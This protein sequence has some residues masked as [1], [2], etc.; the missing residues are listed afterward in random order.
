MPILPGR[1]AR[2]CEVW[3]RPS[4]S[5]ATSDHTSGKLGRVGT[6]GQAPT[7]PSSSPL[8]A[9]AIKIA[10][11][12][13][14]TWALVDTGADFTMMQRGFYEG[15]HVLKNTALKP[16]VRTA[17][18]A[19]GGSLQ[20]AG[21]LEDIPLSINGVVFRCPQMTV[22]DEL[23]YDV[24]LGRDF[25][26][27]HRT[28]VDDITGTIRIGGMSIPL[29][30]RDQV[31]PRRARVRLLSTVTIPA[32]SECVVSGK[33]ERVDGTRP[34]ETG[35]HGIFEPAVTAEREGLL[36]PRVLVAAD[37]DGSVPIILSNFGADEVR[38]LRG[39]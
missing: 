26:C 19:G 2:Q 29:P 25:S 36:T 12:G 33:L 9:S 27:M 1:D 11:H 23:V 38:V 4:A 28:V 15:N 34:D 21:A 8:T 37:V 5:P 31:R 39:E 10:V 30:T 35:V 22:V 18:G 24:I 7:L 14:I 20:I 32:R 6:A 3:D 17:V 16:S 13:S